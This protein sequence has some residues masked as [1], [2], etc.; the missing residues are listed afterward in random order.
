MNRDRRPGW[1]RTHLS[2]FLDI[3]LRR[4]G[5]GMHEYGERRDLCFAEESHIHTTIG[6]LLDIR[7]C[8]KVEI[9]KICV[10]YKFSY[11]TKKSLSKL[12]KKYKFYG[13]VP[14]SNRPHCKLVLR[15]I[16]S[17][18]LW[19]DN[20]SNFNFKLSI[21]KYFLIIIKADCS[22]I[23]LLSNFLKRYKKVYITWLFYHGLRKFLSN[24]LYSLVSNKII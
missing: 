2:L 9:V 12:I 5:L 15:G 1:S 24:F 14:L 3:L 16:P 6:F 19:S 4:F 23:K 22:Y 18:Y 11:F 21:F 20:I 13:D 17:V 8:F 7:L 10:N